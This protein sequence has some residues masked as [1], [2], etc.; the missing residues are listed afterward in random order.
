MEATSIAAP[1]NSALPTELQSAQAQQATVEQQLFDYLLDNS[2]SSAAVLTDPSAL[3]G[4]AM[5]SLEG[6][7]TQAQKAFDAANASSFG[8]P[9][10]AAEAGTSAAVNLD[11]ANAGATSPESM[12]QMLDRAISVM[13]AT[14]NV[15]IA[16]NSL[17][18]ATGS[19]STLLKQQ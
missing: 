17:S 16:T 8:R 18:A 3:I 14:A 1:A 2:M 9:E 19:A 15:S 12:A 10:T 11:A 5:E 6:L 7:A 13:W 4:S